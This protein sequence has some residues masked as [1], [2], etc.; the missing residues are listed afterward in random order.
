MKTI[1]V[2]ELDSQLEEFDSQY[3]TKQILQKQQAARGLRG[4]DCSRNAR[5]AVFVTQ[6]GL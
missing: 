5:A 1:Q 6:R 3:F 2:E 4:H